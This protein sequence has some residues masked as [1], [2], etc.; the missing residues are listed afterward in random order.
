MSRKPHIWT[1]EQIEY[2]KKN[3][4]SKTYSDIQNL[5]NKHFDLN[6]SLNQIRGFAKRN[7]LTN[8]LDCRFKKNNEPWNK[9]MKGVNFGGIETQFKKGQVPA[10]YKPVGSERIDVKDGYVLIKICDKGRNQDRWKLKHRV[11]WEKAHGKS[12]PNGHTVIFADGNK[13]NM[14]IDNLVLVSRRQLSQLNLRGFLTGDPDVLQAGL[15]IINIDKKIHDIEVKGGNLESFNE[16][17]EIAKRNGIEGNTFNARLRRGW[18]LELA[19]SA[20]LHTRRN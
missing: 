13:L 8:G 3:I 16:A 11:V 4:K 17:L 10:N 20:P 18:P 2:F 7:H 14:A 9:G 15:N 19:M 6:L 12:I 5:I 1:N